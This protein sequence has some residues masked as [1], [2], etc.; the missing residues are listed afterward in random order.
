MSECHAAPL[1]GCIRMFTG[2]QP[3]ALVVEGT[4][5]SKHPAWALALPGM[6]PGHTVWCDRPLN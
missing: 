2:R 3:L 5:D 1:L 6:L 4:G